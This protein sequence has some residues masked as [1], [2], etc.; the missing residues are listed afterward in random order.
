MRKPQTVKALEEL[1]RVRLSETF[2]M[3]DFLHSE[4]ADF[5]GIPNIPDDPDLAIAAGR[6][7]CEAL[8]EPLQ[9]TFGRIAIRSAYR[10]PAVNDFGSRNGLSCARNEANYAGHIWDRRDADGCMGATACIVVPWFADRYA[11]GADWRALA[12]W[13]H[14]HLPYSSLQFFPRLAAFNL[15]WHE[16]PLRRIDSYIAPK[17]C[18][19]KP[20]MDNH[21]G[22]HAEWYAGFPELRRSCCLGAEADDRA[23]P[24]K[25]GV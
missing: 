22:S 17:G 11:Q 24:L 19:T 20:G 13:I 23:P 25:K 5:H 10:S 16:R 2:F 18:L 3:R 14:D 8:L 21:A 4:I 7:L 6:Q 1:G 12:W 9:A 15:T